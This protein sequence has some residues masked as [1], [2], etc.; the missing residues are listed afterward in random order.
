MARKW[1]SYDDDEL[2]LYVVLLRLD[3]HSDEAIGKFFQT[4]KGAAVGFRHRK[5]PKFINIPRASKRRVTPARFEEL[6]E[7]RAARSAAMRVIEEN[8]G[9]AGPY[10]EKRCPR[11]E[12]ARQAEQEAEGS[13]DSAK[14]AGSAREKAASEDTS[15]LIPRPGWPD[16]S[17]AWGAERPPLRQGALHEAY[18]CVWNEHLREGRCFA[19]G[20]G[21]PRLCSYHRVAFEKFSSARP[22]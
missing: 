8:R 16:A 12:T 10:V 18:Q 20:E 19:V 11:G 2:M 21:E 22:R 1:R 4:T 17:E 13:I 3:G 15:G 14:Q 6:C 7:S 5:L 9:V